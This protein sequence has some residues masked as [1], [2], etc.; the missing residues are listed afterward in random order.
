MIQSFLQSPM[1]EHCFE[2]QDFQPVSL[3]KRY[4]IFKPERM[5]ESS[6]DPK[7]KARCD[8]LQCP[9][10]VPVVLMARQG[11]TYN[12]HAEVPNAFPKMIFKK[13]AF[14]YKK[15]QTTTARADK[16]PWSLSSWEGTALSLRQHNPQ[17]AA[18]LLISLVTDTGANIDLLPFHCEFSPVCEDIVWNSWYR[19][20]NVG[21]R[22]SKCL[23]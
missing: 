7:H 14:S 18:T 17:A 21:W 20:T 22:A 19:L 16:L 3:L 11:A 23:C 12:N 13:H 9:W 4:F 1:S 10:L 8:W 5:I 15:T 6:L 2:D